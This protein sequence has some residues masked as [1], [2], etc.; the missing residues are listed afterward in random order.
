MRVGT[1]QSPSHV[2]SNNGNI[3]S[4]QGKSLSWRLS[5]RKDSWYSFNRDK[6]TGENTYQPIEDPLPNQI[7]EV[8][9]TLFEQLGSPSFL[10]A[11]ANC[12]TQN[13]NESFHHLVWQL[14]PK[15]IYT[16]TN[17]TKCALFL[18]SDSNYVN[19]QG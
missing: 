3:Q 11:V 7:V 14:A 12:R 5:S 13:V 18:F 16:S 15:E 4:L 10:S 6:A 9:K 1:F 19:W 2:C 17:E 8:V